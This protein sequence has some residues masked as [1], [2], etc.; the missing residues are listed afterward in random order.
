MLSAQELAAAGQRVLLLERQTAGQES[1]WAGGGIVSPLYPWRY[2]AAITRLAQWGQAH[3]PDWCEALRQNSGVDPQYTR[4]GL[5]ILDST[6]T[7]D[8]KA[9]AETFDYQ[10]EILDE[11]GLARCEPSLG[12]ALGQGI[13]LPQVGQVRNPRLTKATRQRILK[14]NTI[15]I[16]EQCNVTGL[17]LDKTRVRGVTTATDTLHAEHVII[18]AGAWSAQFGL[19][20]AVEPVRGQMLVFQAPPELLSRIV[21][22]DSHYLIPRR[23]GH[24]LVGSTLERV[25]FEKQ[26]TPQA[27]QALTQFAYQLI[28][29][30]R[31]CPLEKHWAGLRPGSPDG[32]PYIGEHPDYTGLYFNTGH[33]RNGVVLGLA[34][35]RLLADL[36]TQ[37]ESILDPRPYALDAPRSAGNSVDKGKT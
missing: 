20:L 9:W 15:D 16:R 25:G 18:A 7:A 17:L 32:T 37:R 8:A 31:K 28:P 33:F 24:V 10:L 13:W 30:L 29:A 34:S 19:D 26:T 35:A 6:E 14:Q 27:L 23:D 11:A 12:E 1:S 22:A 4:S 21:L 3:Y 5:L 36:V 2:N